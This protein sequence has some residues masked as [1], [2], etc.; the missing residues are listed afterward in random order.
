VRTGAEVTPQGVG[1]SEQAAVPT[2]GRRW[3]VAF[4]VLSTLL[5]AYD[6]VVLGFMWAWWNDPNAPSTGLATNLVN[7][8]PVVMGLGFWALVACAAP[9]A[10][11]VRSL[12]RSRRRAAYSSIIGG[13][14]A[15]QVGSFG[16]Y[17]Y[18][19]SLAWR[20]VSF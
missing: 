15:L 6:L 5:L 18:L 14:L 20:H 13:S 10:S 8:G 16:L 3:F 2:G 19:F 7:G 9:A 11:C 4:C 1:R 12:R 17:L